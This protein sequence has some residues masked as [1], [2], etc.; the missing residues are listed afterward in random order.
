[1]PC[2]KSIS[3]KLHNVAN[4]L[5][6]LFTP[7]VMACIVTNLFALVFAVGPPVIVKTGESENDGNGPVL[8]AVIC[9]I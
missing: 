3:S 2:V 8:S 1:M 9:D 4:A 7:S 6:G 5:A